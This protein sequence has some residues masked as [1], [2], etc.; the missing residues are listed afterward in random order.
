[1]PPPTSLYTVREWPRSRPR[2]GQLL[3]ECLLALVLVAVASL[4]LA[5]TSVSIAT[6]GDDALQLARA[7]REQGNAVGRTLLAPCDSATGAVASTRWPT[8]R[9]RVDE[10]LTTAGTLHR[11]RVDVGWT[12]SALA[13]DAARELHVSSAGR[14]R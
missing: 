7:Q 4:L 10:A 5:G 11:S 8:S 13:T 1:M 2:R 12:A 3:V 14:C 9:L 6:L